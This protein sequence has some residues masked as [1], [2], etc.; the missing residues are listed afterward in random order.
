M[1]ISHRF[2]MTVMMAV[3]VSVTLVGCH[4]GGVSD[5]TPTMDRMLQDALATDVGTRYEA[6]AADCDCT[7]RLMQIV[8]TPPASRE[9]LGE[10]L[11]E[12][13][14]YVR[15]APNE[16]ACQLGLCLLMLATAADNVG[17]DL[18]QDLFEAF[19]DPNM[20]A[21]MALG[22]SEK[23]GSLR[24]RFDSPQTPVG[25]AQNGAEL[26]FT[27]EEFRQAIRQELLPVLYNTNGGVYQRLNSVAENS[28]S[29]VPL[30][31]FA[32]PGSDAVTMY[33]A[34]FSM[35]AASVLGVYG[36]LLEGLAYSLDPG[37][38]TM[39]ED[40]TQADLNNDNRIT[41]DEYM[42]ATSFG[43]LDPVYGADYM[44]RAYNAYVGAVDDALW[45]TENVPTD[46]P[47]DMMNIIFGELND[48]GSIN[49]VQVEWPE[50]SLEGFNLILRHL[51]AILAGPVEVTLKYYNES[52]TAQSM[53]FTID[54]RQ[55]FLNPVQ[56]IRDLLPAFEYIIPAG[57]AQDPSPAWEIIPLEWSDFPDLTFKGLLPDLPNAVETIEDYDYLEIELP[58]GHEGL[59]LG[60]PIYLPD[61][62]ATENL[63][64]EDW[65]EFAAGMEA[66]IEDL[67][68]LLIGLA[69]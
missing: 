9:E 48:P 40:P 10:A 51:E 5:A 2:T 67:L 21:V 41:P 39:P 61:F 53:P 1:K 37:D 17:A 64:P 57:L 19:A 33:G 25:P 38:W 31:T 56:D 13:I 30:C 58:G 42:P 22:A 34:D 54:V 47:T 14:G 62:D 11:Q 24:A 20:A 46:D 12:F 44:Q 63:T 6:S 35:M 52:E 8:Q 50:T 69:A 59:N 49:I 26:N 36:M 65:E 28:D 66:F 60:G 7:T 23:A 32:I 15:Q 29:T 16:P 45:A 18:G 4:G 3:L 43:T 68:F 55:L 27:E